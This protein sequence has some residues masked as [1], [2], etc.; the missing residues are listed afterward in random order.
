[1]KATNKN[2]NEILPEF[3]VSVMAVAGTN[4][5]ALSKVAIPSKCKLAHSLLP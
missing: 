1:M 5:M 4:H 3:D 2:H